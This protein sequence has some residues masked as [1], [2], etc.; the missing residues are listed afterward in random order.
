M[1]SPKDPKVGNSGDPTDIDCGELKQEY[2]DDLVQWERLKAILPTL[3][4]SAR[5]KAVG[6]RGNCK[7]N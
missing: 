3:T 7:V 6:D 5:A 4:G 1:K 2:H